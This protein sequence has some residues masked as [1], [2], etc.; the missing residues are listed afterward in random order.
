VHF[1]DPS[2]PEGILQKDGWRVFGDLCVQYACR[3]SLADKRP[4]VR[5]RF[6]RNDESTEHSSRTN[7]HKLE[8][9]DEVGRRVSNIV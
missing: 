6:A 1:R 8:D 2:T 9:D 7:G 3:K 5:G 4:R